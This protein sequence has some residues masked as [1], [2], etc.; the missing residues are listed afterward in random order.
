MNIDDMIG[1]DDAA[2]AGVVA[3]RARQ[4]SARPERLQAF[5]NG[6]ALD[7]TLRRPGV[8]SALAPYMSLP[9]PEPRTR[10][11]AR[12]ASAIARAFS[13]NG[14]VTRADLEAEGFDDAEIGD[15]FTEA[16]RVSRVAEMVI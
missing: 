2:F 6:L 5:L 4:L 1:Q 8:Q 9:K 16:R 11:R 14:C 10:K 7:G 15:L 13:S 12:M 3:A